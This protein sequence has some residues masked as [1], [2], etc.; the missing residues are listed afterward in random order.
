MKLGVETLATMTAQK[1]REGTGEVDDEGDNGSEKKSK[2][3]LEGKRT[4][5]ESWTN[6]GQERK[7]DKTRKVH[8]ITAGWLKGSS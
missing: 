3:T 1:K 2:D 7:E 8:G 6:A 4:K 5:D